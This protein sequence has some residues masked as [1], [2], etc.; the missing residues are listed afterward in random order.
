[1]VRKTT[2]DF[3][4]KVI[5]PLIA[6]SFF[7]VAITI[8]RHTS[9][10]EIK[11]SKQD[12]AY[13]L[14]STFIRFVSLGNK[15]V[16]SN[17]LWIQT[18]MESDIERHK[19]KNFADWMYLR[20]LTISVLDPL[21]YENYLYGGMYLSVIKDDLKGAAEIFELGL[22]KYPGDYRILYYAG[23]NYFFEMGDYEN[24]YRILKQ[25]RN[26]EKTPPM[27]KQV[28]NKLQFEVSGDFDLAISLLKENLR[29]SKD[30]RV[31]TKLEADLYAVTTERDLNCLNDKKRND[32]SLRDT[33][34]YPYVKTINGWRAQ[35]DFKPYR[36]FRKT[37]SP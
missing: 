33:R 8:H 12:S 10:P 5:I 25:L 6:F 29:L 9:K 17:V 14:N 2:E 26:H 32:C 11:I 22:R 1:M 24:G 13:T 30:D 20:F 27:L 7:L 31:K 23:F 19:R 15:R 21:F 16:F 18:L 4:S 3:K 28:I 35:F 37:H 34:G 36:I